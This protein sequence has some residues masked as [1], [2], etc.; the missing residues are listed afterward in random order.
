[1]NEFSLPTRT[2]FLVF[3]GL[4]CVGTGLIGWYEGFVEQDFSL[5]RF[6]ENATFILV[7]SMGWSVIL[8]EGGNMFY[9]SFLEEREKKGRQE[10]RQ[11]GQEEGQ[12]KERE[13]V[14]NILRGKTLSTEDGTKKVLTDE[15]LDVLLGRAKDHKP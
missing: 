10:G 5:N 8:T 11:E 7:V 2:H 15:N 6:L 13:R 14:R 4:S 12:E 9:E 1:M 3:A